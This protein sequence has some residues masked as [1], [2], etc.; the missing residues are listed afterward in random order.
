MIP[1]IQPP[2][3]PSSNGSTATTHALAGDQKTMGFLLGKLIR[4]GYDYFFPPAPDET[5]KPAKSI[6]IFNDV[7]EGILS[8]MG[9]YQPLPKTTK[10]AVVSGQSVSG[11]MASIVLAKAG[12]QVDV[13]DVRSAFTRNIQWA[14]RQALVDTLADIDSTLDDLFV[15]HVAKPIYEG[16][17]HVKDESRRVKKHEGLREGDPSQLPTNGS[18]MMSFPSVM[19]LEARVFEEFL[20][21]Y[22]QTF[23][24]ICH[25]T[26]SITLEQNGE[27]FAVTK[28]G[29]PDLVVV[30]EGASSRTRNALE[31]Q[32]IPL[33]EARRQIAGAIGIDSKGVMIKQWKTEK[34]MHMLTGAIGHA[35]LNKTWI[36]ADIDS[37]IGAEQTKIDAEFR[38]LAAE[39]L[40]IP[41]ERA[42]ALEIYG[43]S[44]GKPVSTFYLQQ[45]IS[46][47]AAVGNNVI[48]IGDT[49]G[50]C[51]W[52]VGGGMQVAAVSHIHRLKEFLSDLAFGDSL[53]VA[54]KNYSDGVLEDTKAWCELGARDFY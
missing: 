51:H 18:H 40:E 26:E 43:P 15:E 20:S 2:S 47:T 29:T 4:K 1:F 13:F 23:P 50:H 10:W 31:I 36:V 12:Y 41:I 35:G 8:L 49:V 48:F 45:A 21:K 30:A 28:H 34:G 44:D 53:K 6:P 37:T 24:N 9:P 54:L 27:T 33:T 25:H 11:M 46:K 39:V 22:I 38:R 7:T 52:S 3:P 19:T 42:N 14:G 5:D 16:S 17:I 32:S